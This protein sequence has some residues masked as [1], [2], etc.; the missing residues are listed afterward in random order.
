MSIDD[1]DLKSLNFNI[2]DYA[3]D[4]NEN[5]KFDVKNLCLVTSVDNAK[6][7]MFVSINNFDADV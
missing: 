2:Q 7:G 4:Y 5:K 3:N 6:Y 1:F